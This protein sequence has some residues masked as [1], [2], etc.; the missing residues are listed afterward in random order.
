M[1]YKHLIIWGSLPVLKHLADA[2]FASF[3]SSWVCSLSLIQ[4][5]LQPVLE[6]IGW[7]VRWGRGFARLLLDCTRSNHLRRWDVAYRDFEPIRMGL[8][9]L[10]SR[11]T[12]PV[13]CDRRHEVGVNRSFK[14]LRASRFTRPRLQTNGATF[15]ISNRR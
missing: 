6:L 2:R 1:A 10:Q 15:R 8:F 12:Y 3:L 7:G 4:R 13:L 11:V 9:L 5:L 14:V